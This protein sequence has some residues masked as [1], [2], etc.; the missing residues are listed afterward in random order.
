L[1]LECQKQDD[2]ENIL[3]KKEEMKGK[4][5][6]ELRINPV[7]PPGNNRLHVY[8]DLSEKTGNQLFDSFAVA[9]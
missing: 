6:Q 4:Q 1:V 2:S 9:R 5:V 3:C 8:T 7:R